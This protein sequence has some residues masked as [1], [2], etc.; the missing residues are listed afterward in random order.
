M[1]NLIT[2][3]GQVLFPG[4]RALKLL[5]S[6]VK[7]TE[8]TSPV[9]V[10]KNITLTVVDCCCAPTIRL[11]VRCAALGVPLFLPASPI[12]IGWNIHLINEIYEECLS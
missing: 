7:L 2:S 4:G 3:A 12:T 5:K 9:G 6:G 8:S 11:P 10:A 1:W